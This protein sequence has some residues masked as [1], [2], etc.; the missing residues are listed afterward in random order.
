MIKRYYGFNIEVTGI[1]IDYIL[2]KAHP[3][4]LEKS[5]IKL[6]LCQMSCDHSNNT[7]TIEELVYKA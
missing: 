5:I 2:F 7:N 4:V 6:A 3:A 1:I